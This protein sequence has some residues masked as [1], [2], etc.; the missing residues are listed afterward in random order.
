MKL[1]FIRGCAYW[2]SFCEV[3]EVCEVI[4]KLAKLDR[5]KSAIDPLFVRT[6]ELFAEL[7]KFAK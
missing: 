5:M 1:V 6:R 3:C 7:A 2:L 4:A